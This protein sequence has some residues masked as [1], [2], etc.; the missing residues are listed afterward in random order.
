MVMPP[1]TAL[2][3]NPAVQV[4]RDQGPLL[5]AVCH[6]ELKD[7]PVF[8]SRPRSLHVEWFAIST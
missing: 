5:W 4:L 7:A 8:L 1:L 6:D 2:L 3:S